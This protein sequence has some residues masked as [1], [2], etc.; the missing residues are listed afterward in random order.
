MTWESQWMTT[1]V[2]LAALARSSLATRASCFASL[3]MVRKSR[4]TIHSILSPFGE[5][6]TIPAPPAC[7]FDNLSVCM[8]HWG[9]SFAPLPSPLVNFVMKSATTCPL[10]VVCG[11]YYISNSLNS[12]ANSTNCLAISGFFITCRNGLSVRMITVWAWKY[13]LS[14]RAVITKVNVSYS[15]GGYLSFAPRS[16]WLA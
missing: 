14:L 8:L 13:G 15:I 5:I 1:L 11:R 12:I 2:A 3:F 7:L 10:M 4:Q 16:A 9:H 6:S